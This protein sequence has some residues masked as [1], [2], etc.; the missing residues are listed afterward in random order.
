MAPVLATSML[1]NMREVDDQ[2]TREV[3]SALLFAPIVGRVDSDI[4][5]VA[6]FSS[7]R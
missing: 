1:L 6:G 3:V 5:A 7:F 2:C 4:R